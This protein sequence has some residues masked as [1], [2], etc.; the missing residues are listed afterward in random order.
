[1]D[2]FGSEGRWSQGSDEHGGWRVDSSLSIRFRHLRSGSYEVGLSDEERLAGERISP[3]PQWSVDELTP[4]KTADIEEGWVSELPISCRL[5]R[6]AGLQVSGS[7]SEPALLTMDEVENL[8]ETFSWRTLNEDEWETCCRSG[9]PELFVWGNA[10]PAHETLDAWLTWD[11]ASDS[12]PR[13]AWGFASLFY[14]EWCSDRFSASRDPESSH[15]EIAR[16]IKGGGARFW[17]W[18]TDREWVWCASAMRMP[19]TDLFDDRRAAFRPCL[20]PQSDSS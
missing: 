5:A 15:D 2:S 8:N 7:D 6:D 4:V 13:N 1:M 12:S 17:P 20:L 3:M 11:L 9:S 10:L 19:S 16:V 14:G 18:Q